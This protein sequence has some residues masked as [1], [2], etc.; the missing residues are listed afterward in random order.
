MH[1][2]IQRRIRDRREAFAAPIEA[3]ARWAGLETERWRA[4]E[5]GAPLSVAELGRVARALAVDAGTLLRGEERSPHRTVARFR[6]AVPLA[7]PTVLEARTLALA[8][9]LGRIGGALHRLLGKSLPLA[10][11]RKPVPVS[12]REEP[13]RQGYRLGEAARRSLGLPLGPVTDLERVLE[14]AGVHVATLPF[15]RS[16]VDAASLMEE[17]AMPVLLLNQTSSRI[18]QPLPRRAAMAHELCHLLHDAGEHD[19]ETQMSRSEGSAQDD[20]AEQRARAFAPALLAPPDEVRHWFTS[21]GGRKIG[22]AEPKVTALAK[23]WGLSWR[24]A[25]WHAKNCRLI[26]PATADRLVG[27][28]G[29]R[30]DWQADFERAETSSVGRLSEGLEPSALCRGR[31]AELVRE[32]LEAGAISEGRAREILSWG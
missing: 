2:D 3:A 30:P 13:W 23:R 26:R 7:G 12:D 16:D 28:P 11:V 29:P 22:D 4:I 20:P 1:Q 19:L 6:Q 27:A 10:G 14:V 18:A 24:G 15:S 5:A 21:G 9:E 32:A 25:V 31:I 17:G 8:A